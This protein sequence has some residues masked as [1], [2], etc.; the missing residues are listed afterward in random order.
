MTPTILC[1]GATLLDELY[2][3]ETTIVAQSS[4]PAHKTIGIGGVICNIAQNLASLGTP[5]ALIT[6]IG[7]DAEGNYILKELTKHGIDSSAFCITDVSTGKYVS[8]LSPQGDLYV[9]V[10]QDNGKRYLSV[11]YL[12]SKIDYIKTFDILIIDTNLDTEVIQWL[13]HFAKL[14]QKILIIEPVSVTKASK[15]ATLDLEGVYMITPNEAE[16]QAICT[17]S[18]TETNLLMA[19]LW[20]RGVQTIWLRQGAMGST[21]FSQS[22]TISLSVPK[23]TIVDST[24]AGDAALAG[25][26]FGIANG[27]LPMTCLK[28]GHT[29][30]MHILQRKGTVDANMNATTI[31]TLMKTYYND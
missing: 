2:F 21:L 11:A 4:N 15:L 22:E 28:L 31:Y 29:L 23:I 10:C 20:H 25:W 1:I 17:E 6:A 12:Q 30:A 16:L 9:A 14:H 5:P 26:V 3:C 27:E 13:I 7:N 18:A 19:S 24:G 8:V